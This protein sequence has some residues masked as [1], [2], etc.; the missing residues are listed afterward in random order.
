MYWLCG[1]THCV[2]TVMYYTPL[3]LGSYPWS[4]SGLAWDSLV[5]KSTRF[6]SNSKL[7]DKSL[8]IQTL[9]S[10]ESMSSWYH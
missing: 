1:I 9:P 3:I 8:R 5:R 7:N 10:V 2:C 6:D 4:R